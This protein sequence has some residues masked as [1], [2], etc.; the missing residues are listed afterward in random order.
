MEHTEK[1]EEC[2]E[3]LYKIVVFIFAAPQLVRTLEDAWPTPIG[4]KR[5]Q[6]IQI[7]AWNKPH[8]A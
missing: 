8:I 6:H 4:Y 1:D 7:I 2:D 5:E 3:T